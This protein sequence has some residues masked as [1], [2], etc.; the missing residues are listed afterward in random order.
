MATRA[1]RAIPA[2]LVVIGVAAAQ[3]GGDFEITRSTIAG[4]GKT[5]GGDY[6]V[7][8]AIGQPGADPTDATGGEFSLRG[9]LYTS[10]AGEREEAIFVDGFEG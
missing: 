5:V 8:G 2:L 7:S 4:G 1:L 9:G 6:Q 3:S 10:P